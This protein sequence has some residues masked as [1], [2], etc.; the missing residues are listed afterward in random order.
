[1][2]PTPP[3]K[4]EPAC[5]LANYRLPDLELLHFDDPSRGELDRQSMLDLA[6]RLEK[7]LADYGVKGRVSEIHPGPVVTMYEFVP[8]AGTKLSK[9]TALSNDLAMTLGSRCRTR[10][11]RRS[12]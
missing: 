3:P 2:P 4:P 12:T 10:R 9:I 11:A 1:V 7:T 5:D 6:G 8:Q